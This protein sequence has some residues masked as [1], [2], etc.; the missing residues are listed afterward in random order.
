VTGTATLFCGVLFASDET[1]LA[2]VI[3]FILIAIIVMNVRFILF[4]MFWMCFTLVEKHEIFRTMF[5]LL[6][7]AT[8][9]R[10]QAAI[11]IEESGIIMQD[12]FSVVTSM[13][14]KVSMSLIYY[15]IKVSLSS[16]KWVQEKVW[17]KQE[18]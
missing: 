12:Q 8:C 1:D 15:L 6:S 10:K 9:R 14:Q 7:T 18:E 4:W 16:P 3:L 17:E 2:L 13:N 11:M 5:N